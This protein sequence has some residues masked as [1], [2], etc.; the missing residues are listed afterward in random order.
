[1]EARFLLTPVGVFTGNK[2]SNSRLCVALCTV[3]SESN[4]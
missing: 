4:I 3:L 1:M 2:W